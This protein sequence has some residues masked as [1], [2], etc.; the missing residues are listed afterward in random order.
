MNDEKNKI[1]GEKMKN[2]KGS[3]T[4]NRKGFALFSSFI[5]YISSLSIFRPS[6]FPFGLIVLFT[7]SFG[8]M[9]TVVGFAYSRH[10]GNTGLDMSKV[11][12][13]RRAANQTK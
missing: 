5:F 9:A 11:Q 12:E 1:L 13:M 6:S 2:E 10:S 3:Q 8:L 7:V 4:R